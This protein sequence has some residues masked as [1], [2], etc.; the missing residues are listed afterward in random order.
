MTATAAASHLAP[1]PGG[2]LWVF[3]YGSLMWRPGFAF[4]ERQPAILH[5]YHRSL[6]VLSFN[7]RGTQEK[8]GLVL[9]L[10]RGGACQGVAYRVAAPAAE[11]TRAYLT[12]REQISM[13]YRERLHPLRLKDGRR[14]AALAY[15]VDRRHRQY[16]GVMTREKQLAHVRQ[17]VGKS[18]ANP[19]YVLNT[20]AHLVEMGVHDALLDWIAAQLKQAR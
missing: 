2:D 13:V 6:C 5:G 3:G 11:E 8:P 16:A 18:G 19:E 10:D 17:G 4:E 15:S 9:G 14:V 12:A 7:H 1:L 20:H